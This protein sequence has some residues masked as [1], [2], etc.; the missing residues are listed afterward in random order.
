MVIISTQR[1]NVVDNLK[2]QWCTLLRCHIFPK[3]SPKS[4]NKT[5]LKVCKCPQAVPSGKWLRKQVGT[6]AKAP[7]TASQWRCRRRISRLKEGNLLYIRPNPPPEIIIAIVGKIDQDY[8]WHLFRSTSAVISAIPQDYLCTLLKVTFE[9]S[10]SYK[11]RM[12][13]EIQIMYLCF[14]IHIYL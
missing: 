5:L 6:C 4:G 1:T 12:N 10:A 8:P 9:S 14:K 2:W 7:S 3:L 13:L 11:F